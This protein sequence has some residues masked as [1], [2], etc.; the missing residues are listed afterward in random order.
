[1]GDVPVIIAGDLNGPAADPVGRQLQAA[2]FHNAWELVHSRPCQVTHTDHRG[3]SFASDHI[4]L[5][6]AVLPST[7]HLLPR[8]IPDGTPMARPTIGGCAKARARD[9]DANFDLWCELSDHRP[10]SGCLIW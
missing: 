4:W 6:G 10:L 5:R 2:G 7:M 8:G 1:M 9:G 3:G